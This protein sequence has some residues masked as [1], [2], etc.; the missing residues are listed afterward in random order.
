MED[1]S[2]SVPFQMRMRPSVKEAG[3]KAARA[4]NRSLSAL[5]EILLIEHLRAEGYLPKARR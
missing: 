4:G 2:R 1:E 3:E 5:I